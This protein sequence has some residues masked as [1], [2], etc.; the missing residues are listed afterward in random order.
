[1]QRGLDDWHLPTPPTIN[2]KLIVLTHDYWENQKF[3]HVNVPW[4]VNRKYTAITH[5]NADDWNVLW[6][7]KGD[8]VGS[9]EQGFIQS[10]Y[11]GQL[12]QGKFI[13]T[14]PCFRTDSQDITHQTHFMKSELHINDEVTKEVLHSILHRAEIF[15]N[16]IAT[17]NTVKVVHKPRDDEY[18]IT[19]NGIEIG[20]YGI[21]QFGTY[22]WIYGTAIAEP[23]FSIAD[24]QKLIIF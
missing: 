13:A 4:L 1:M 15:F 5:N 8:L 14:S 23:R 21:R 22:K 24:K 7:R 6:T 19:L 3:E 18:D 16:T 17:S 11:D 2:W 10:R 9:A 20:S 12:K